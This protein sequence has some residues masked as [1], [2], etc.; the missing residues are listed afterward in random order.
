[1]TGHGRWS[2]L[3][4]RVNQVIREHE[5][6]I[7]VGSMTKIGK[8][9]RK[10]PIYSIISFDIN[11]LKEKAVGIKLANKYKWHNAFCIF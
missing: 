10:R 8:I 6:A 4:G 3:I 2:Y 9:S 11:N 7:F 5:E 1:L